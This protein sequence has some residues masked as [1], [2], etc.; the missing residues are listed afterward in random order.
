MRREQRL[1]EVLEAGAVES[2]HH[3]LAH[4]VGEPIDPRTGGAVPTLMKARSVPLPP[5][6]QGAQTAAIANPSHNR[7][8]ISN[9]P[10]AEVI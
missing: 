2:D 5:P 1:D 4:E 6:A 3:P 7:H 8:T 10:P 9:G